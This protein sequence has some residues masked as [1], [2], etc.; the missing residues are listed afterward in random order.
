MGWVIT[1]KGIS[2]ELGAQEV[3]VLAHLKHLCLSMEVV[4]GGLLVAASDHSQSF[5]LDPLEFFHRRLADVW[6][7]D[8]AV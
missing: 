1:L 4:N 6:L 2:K 5:V 3:D 7:P 8:R